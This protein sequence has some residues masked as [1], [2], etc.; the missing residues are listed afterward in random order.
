[1]ESPSA[2]TVV[3]DACLLSSP[4]DDVLILGQND[5]HHPLAVIRLTDST[6]S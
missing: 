4:N 3:E 2:N 5:E 1:M 6:V